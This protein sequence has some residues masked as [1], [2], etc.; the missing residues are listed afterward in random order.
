MFLSK[1]H[2]SFDDHGS[3]FLECTPLI[4]EALKADALTFEGGSL[5]L[6]LGFLRVAPFNV[7]SWISE[8]VSL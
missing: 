4:I 1:G 7:G 2:A 5:M 3:S 6:V 8:G